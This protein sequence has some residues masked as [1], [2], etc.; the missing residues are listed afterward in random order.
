MERH[1]K[2]SR[3]DDLQKMFH[4]S[5]LTFAGQIEFSLFYNR[6]HPKDKGR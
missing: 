1:R 5:Q 3:G 6:P 2:P 4:I